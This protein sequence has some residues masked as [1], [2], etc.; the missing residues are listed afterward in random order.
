MLSLLAVDAI[1]ASVYLLI[2]AGHGDS[3]HECGEGGRERYDVVWDGSNA[4]RMCKW[5]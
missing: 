1:F 3:D 5:V 4:V 2:Q